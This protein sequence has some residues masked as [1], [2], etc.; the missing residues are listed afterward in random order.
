MPVTKSPLRYPGGK[1]QLANYVRHLL[2]IN[3]IKDTYIEPFA[4]GFGVGLD[5]LI[6]NSVKQVV[7]NDLDTSIDAI[8]YSIMN[9]MDLFI[10]KI[11]DTPVT[12]EEWH[13]QRKIREECKNDYHSIDNAFASFFLN[14]TNVSGIINGGPIGGQRQEGK[15]KIDCRYNKDNLI[16]KIKLINQY[17]EKIRLTHLDANELIKKG[18]PNY[19]PDSTFIF[20]DPPYYVQGKNLYL[21]FVDQSEHKELA[22]NILSLK[23]YKWITTYDI[24]DEIFKLYKPYVKAYTYTL[25]YSANRKRKAKEFMFV[26][27]NTLADSFERVELNKI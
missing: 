7:I 2:K 3:R 26:N 16:K 19:S 11:N 27:N 22:K 14:R 4:G 24:E 17:K 15:Y 6:T 5:L 25:N 9:N 20:F 23:K 10:E 21:S 12:I 1:T 13:K 8:W 18:I